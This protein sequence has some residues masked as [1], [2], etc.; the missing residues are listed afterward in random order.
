MK[1]QRADAGTRWR[2][3]LAVLSG[4]LLLF[5]AACG[6]EEEPA[7]GPVA[8]VGLQRALS[9]SAGEAATAA[10]LAL[11]LA[12]VADL[13]AA[14]LLP[15]SGSIEGASTFDLHEPGSPA[16]PKQMNKSHSFQTTP[17]PDPAPEGGGS[18]TSSGSSSGESDVSWSKL[19]VNAGSWLATSP[20][21]APEGPDQGSE[22]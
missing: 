5:A 19:D 16:A 22:Q 7:T 2:A 6:A 21:P 13:S 18:S 10:D 17:S 8:E 3:P 14:E 11:M 9:L 20:D 1:I 12:A 4:L 15:S